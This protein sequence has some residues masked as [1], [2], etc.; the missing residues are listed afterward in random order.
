[1][2]PRAWRFDFVVLLVRMWR[3]NAAPRTTLPVPVFL[4]RFAAP[5]WVFNFCFL[6]MFPIPGPAKAGRYVRYSFAAVSATS[7]FFAAGFG[8]PFLPVR[9]VCI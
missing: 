4:N 2:L 5:R 1:M 9:M 8:A 3:L 7:G 6:A